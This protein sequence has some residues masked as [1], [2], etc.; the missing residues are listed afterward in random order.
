MC[1]TPLSVRCVALALTVAVAVGA[2]ARAQTFQSRAVALDRVIGGVAIRT[3]ERDD[4]TVSITGGAGVIEPP[5]AT[6]DDGVVRIDGAPG[7][8]NRSCRTRNER[9]EIR[10]IG[11]DFHALEDY[12]QIVIEAP[13]DVDVTLNGGLVFGEAG[14]IGQAQVRIDSCGDFSIA[15]VDGPADL[16]INGS[17]DLTVGP[18]VSAEVSIN[19]SGDVRVGASAGD[20]SASVTGSGDVRADSVNG[21]LTAEVSGSGDIIIEAGRA[22][23]FKATVSGSGDV[24]FGGVAVDPRISIFGSGDVRLAAV[25]GSMRYSGSGSGEVRVGE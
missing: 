5:T 18:V 12:P 19:G 11:R 24:R 4:I 9:I 10:L 25:E 17:G 2:E 1:I 22:T 23:G 21:R 16:A 6:L 14:P 15:A 7:Y 20:L 13:R 3:T 8:R